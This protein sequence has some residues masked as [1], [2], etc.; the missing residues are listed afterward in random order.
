[1]F[2]GRWPQIHVLIGNHKEE[3]QVPVSS[4]A[5]VILSE[6]L[7]DLSR[8]CCSHPHFSAQTGAV[9]FLLVTVIVNIKLILDTRRAISEASEDPEPEQDYGGGRLR[10]G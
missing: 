3:R 6:G 5:K 10:V 7:C 8:A 2:S 1:M 4:P 9:L